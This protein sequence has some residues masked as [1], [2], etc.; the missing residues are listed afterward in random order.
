MVSGP[1]FF[2]NHC[3]ELSM[4]D[5][6]QLPNKFRDLMDIETLCLKHCP[7]IGQIKGQEREDKLP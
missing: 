4:Q 2:A 7:A 3:S 5:L 1:F 6:I